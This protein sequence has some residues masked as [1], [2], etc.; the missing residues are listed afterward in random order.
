MENIIYLITIIVYGLFI[1]RFILSWIGGDFELDADADLDLSDV[2]SFKGLNHFIMG[3][4]GWLSIKTYTTHIIEWYDF[5][6]AFC[7]GIVFAIILFYIYKFMMKLESK[8]ETL[9]GSELV[10]KKG[11]VYL[12]QD[13][14]YLITVS[15]G[16]GTIEIPGKSDKKLKVGDVVVISD[17]V[18]GYYTLV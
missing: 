6:I 16:N 18:G 17:Y 12:N 2:I 9:S 4:T 13:G 15:N 1:I 8:P 5:I 11:T 7:I 14:H 3:V 10:G